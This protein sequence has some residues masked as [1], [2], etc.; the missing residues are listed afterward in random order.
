MRQ[1]STGRLVAGLCLI[2]VAVAL[3]FVLWFS[4]GERAAI[5]G[6]PGS[7]APLIFGIFFL[8]GALPPRARS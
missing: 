2:A 4:A 8:V 6:I 3:P 1:A 7:L 5:I